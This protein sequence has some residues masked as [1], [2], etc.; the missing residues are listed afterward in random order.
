MKK[1]LPFRINRWDENARKA[2]E[3]EKLKK[4][5]IYLFIYLICVYLQRSITQ[6]VTAFSEC[7][8]MIL[9]FYYLLT[10]SPFIGKNRTD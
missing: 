5:F 4:K 10:N 3:A 6:Y 1:I 9:E 7:N 2:L 8:K